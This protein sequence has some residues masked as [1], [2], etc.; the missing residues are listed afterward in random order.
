MDISISYEEDRGAS[1]FT[2]GEY[3]TCDV[4]I[5]VDKELPLR[6]QQT[7][8]IHAVI[9]NFCRN[10]AHETILELGDLIQDALDKLEALS[11]R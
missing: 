3:A 11:G 7:L 9:E 8:V 1:V 10:W 4:K 5:Y 2:G 6:E